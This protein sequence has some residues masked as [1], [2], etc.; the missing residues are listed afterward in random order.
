MQN[1]VITALLCAM[2]S[3]AAAAAPET[4]EMQEPAFVVAEALADSAYEQEED[5]VTARD[6]VGKTRRNYATQLDA[7]DYLLDKRYRN[8][9][10]EFTKKWYDH[11]FLEAGAGLFK[12]LPQ[13]GYAFDPLTALHLSVGKQFDKVNSLR[14]NMHIEYGYQ[15]G[16]NHFMHRYGM[17]LD[18]LF[19][20][21][22]YFNGYNPARTVDIS[23]VIGL[24]YQKAEMRG[25]TIRD[26]SINMR[27]G[28]QFRF[29]TGPQGY[30]TFEPYYEMATNGSDLGG[31][32]NYRAV[33]MGFGAS[34]GFVYYLHNN[35]SREARERYFHSMDEA[36]KHYNN[37]DSVPQSWRRP[38]FVEFSNGINML[39]SDVLSL[40]ET[41][42]NEMALSV[43]KW[44]SP[45]L[46]LR[47]TAFSRTAKWSEAMNEPELFGNYRPHIQ[48]LNSVYAGARIDAMFNPFG[49]FKNFN[50]DSRYGVYLVAGGEMGRMVKYQRKHLNCRSE[51]YTAGAHLWYKLSD[52][53]QLFVEPRFTSYAYKIP[54]RNVNWNS[55]FTDTGYTISAGLT[56]TSR[57]RR[58][59][60]HVVPAADNGGRWGFIKNIEVGLGGGM[61]LTQ[62]KTKYTDDSQYGF[63]GH[64]FAA[65]HLNHLS[66]VRLAFDYATLSGSAMSSYYDINN[67]LQ[68]GSD[69]HDRRYGLWNYEYGLGIV[70]LAY[71]A[72]LTNLLNGWR[73]ARRFE[74]S[75][76][77]GPD[78]MFQMGSS[79][80]LSERESLKTDHTVQL[81]KGT[82]MSPAFGFHGGLKL[83]ARITD[84][85]GAFLS[86]TIHVITTDELRGLDMLRMRY[87]E[88]VN[89]GVQY[90]F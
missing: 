32:R 5:G 87:I 2:F 55:K 76:F 33:D 85:I 72:N 29:F 82:S 7:M 14:L 66:S 80:E 60:N 22:S 50:W 36:G 48:D 26:K 9:G 59:H 41:M 46:A 81:E 37:A 27:L 53:L 10:D 30:L 75:A 16:K 90:K 43:G 35:L 1:K 34:V 49:L 11:M 62:L 73:P 25:G 63:G 18:H 52:G 6:T 78:V 3:V 67:N 57:A 17:R 40:T 24:G 28:A 12:I 70:S 89:L 58:F 64:F 65:Y 38:W 88:T 8:R 74:L 4:S 47:L 44:L 39:Q 21:S 77:A 15:E 84:H 42:G 51:A 54:Y 31:A 71:Q 20:F 23:S 56:V 69:G 83:S 19:S 79:A 68:N 86:P 13:D 45:A 61:N